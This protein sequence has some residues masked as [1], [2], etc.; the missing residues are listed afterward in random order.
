ME[1]LKDGLTIS[2]GGGS[3]KRCCH[4]RRDPRC[5]HVVQ[6]RK[7]VTYMDHVLKGGATRR[8]EPAG[9]VSYLQTKRYPEPAPYDRLPKAWRAEALPSEAMSG[10]T[11]ADVVSWSHEHP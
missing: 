3:W 9:S 8:L 11:G 6:Y 2:G 7:G 4:R 10:F 5:C 1:W